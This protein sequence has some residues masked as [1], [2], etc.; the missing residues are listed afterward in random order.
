MGRAVAEAVEPIARPVQLPL[1]SAGDAAE[2]AVEGY[3]R[4][5]T[6]VEAKR[7]GRPPG[8]VNRATAD[9]R[10][11]IL[12]RY[13]SPLVALAETYSR[14]VEVLAAELGCTKAEAM[15][16]QMRAAAELAPYLHG[17]MPV[18]VN[19]NGA[20]LVSLTLITGQAQGAGG[21][22]TVLGTI[23]ENQGVGDEVERREVERDGSSD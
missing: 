16:M 3:G 10:A 19:L 5:P 22:E 11:Y 17:K 23:I 1:L 13:P 15:A 6:L 21:V 8:A 18:E 9:W 14:P 4:L 12:A 2:V 20:G 7:I